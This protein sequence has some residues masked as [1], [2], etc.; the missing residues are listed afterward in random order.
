MTHFQHNHSALLRQHLAQLQLSYTIGVLSNV[1]RL[2]QLN[3]DGTS[4]T[5][6]HTDEVRV[7]LSSIASQ[8]HNAHTSLDEVRAEMIA[9]GEHLGKTHEQMDAFA[10]LI[11]EPLSGQIKLTFGELMV[12]VLLSPDYEAYV[13]S[14]AWDILDGTVAI[15]PL[16]YQGSVSMRLQAF[17]LFCERPIHSGLS[18]TFGEL[19]V[20]MV[21]LGA[22]DRHNALIKWADGIL[23]GLHTQSD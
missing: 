15:H 20:Q 13:R 3:C 18:L 8:L 4:D 16:S 7:L 11:N 19:M 10:K 1:G 14:L 2:C 17:L 12:G 22:N 5:L 6:A 23:D 21:V 9:I